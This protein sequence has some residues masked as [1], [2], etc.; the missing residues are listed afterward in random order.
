MLSLLKRGNLVKETGQGE[1]SSNWRARAGRCRSEVAQ[2]GGGFCHQTD[3]FVVVE[4][5][6]LFYTVPG[7][8]GTR[9]WRK[10][11]SALWH[12]C[13]ASSVRFRVA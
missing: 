11:V 1:W 3:G 6:L 8:S 5:R 9:N 10:L 7:I 13:V 4:E 2:N 12:M